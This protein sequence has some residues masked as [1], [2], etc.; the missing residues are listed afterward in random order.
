MLT[1]RILRLVLTSLFGLFCGFLP[2]SSEIRAAGSD[3]DAEYR[4]PN[5]GGAGY[6]IVI[7]K[8]KPESGGFSYLMNGSAENLCA[9]LGDEKCAGGKSLNYSAILPQCSAPSQLDCIV[10]FGTSNENDDKALGTF[11]GTFPTVGRNQFVGDSAANLPS[12]GAPTLW[13]M[14][15]RPHSGGT[16]YMVQVQSRGQGQG[17]SFLLSDFNIEIQ[18]VELI[19]DVCIPNQ[20]SD[21][22]CAQNAG[23][24]FYDIPIS[25]IE[26]DEKGNELPRETKVGG[27]SRVSMT[28]FD[29]VVLAEDKCARRHALPPGTRLYVKVRLSQ[30]P[31]GW[32]HGRIS[33]PTVT[34]TPLSGTAVELT[35]SAAAVNTPVI[36]QARRYS[37]LPADLQQAYQATGGFKGASPGTRNRSTV[38]SAP[39]IRNA[40]SQPVSSSATGMTELLMWLPH[41][42]D[43]A[44]ANIGTWTVRSL[45]AGELTGAT[46]CFS[47]AGQ[48]NG[49]VMT[50][51]TQYSAGPPVFDIAAGSLEYKVAA[52]HY[53]S[54][55]NLF[56]GTY[57]LIMRSDVARCLYGFS[58]A[59]LNASISVIDNDGVATVATKLVSEKNGWLR[60]SAYGFNFSNP[61]IKVNLTQAVSEVTKT[62]V[63]KKTTITCK[64]GKSVKKVSGFK[65]VCP[66]GFRKV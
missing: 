39:E 12:G 53:T 59:P 36:A 31:T 18:P 15:S 23:P 27:A 51:A 2:T 32:L 38:T 4:D 37:T 3:V 58:K 11:I 62:S 21:A 5:E 22:E 1:R 61:T 10:E 49:L 9:S 47:T 63:S 26:Y 13:S 8:D 17:G 64:N 35:V 50:N 55:G 52:P 30:T 60:I 65:P 16:T 45:S 42:N 43:T 40:I 29:C 25:E 54:G 48:L 44:T 20:G 66:K 33:Q 14:A 24:G 19:A 46:S 57:D 34:L 6:Q 28:A 7:F 56:T 41:I